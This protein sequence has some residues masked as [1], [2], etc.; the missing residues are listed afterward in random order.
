MSK[1]MN[2]T[3]TAK[4]DKT[5]YFIFA[6]RTVD[7]DIYIVFMNFKGAADFIP[8]RRLLVLNYKQDV[9]VVFHFI[10]VETIPTGNNKIMG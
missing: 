6:V 4:V 5:T 9:F 1:E 3:S 2:K 8:V 7:W 10:D